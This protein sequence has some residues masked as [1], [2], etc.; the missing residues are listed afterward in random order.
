MS[1]F[2]K[3]PLNHKQKS[4]Q[5]DLNSTFFCDMFSKN[6]F[7]S[8]KKMWAHISRCCCYFVAVRLYNVRIIAKVVSN[9]WDLTCIFPLMKVERIFF[10]WVWHFSIMELVGNRNRS[11]EADKSFL[12]PL[13]IHQTLQKNAILDFFCTKWGYFLLC[14]FITVLNVVRRHWWKVRSSK[15][16]RNCIVIKI[17]EESLLK[18][19]LPTFNFNLVVQDVSQQLNYMTFGT[20]QVKVNKH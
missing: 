1:L 17:N 6:S 4:H 18:I 14:N 5:F 3:I 2:L 12:V 9:K 7:M 10:P 20:Q 19:F 15:F 8:F 11:F 16:R 13:F